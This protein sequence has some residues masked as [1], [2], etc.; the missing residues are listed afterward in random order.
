MALQYFAA[1]RRWEGGEGGGGHVSTVLKPHM[2]ADDLRARPETLT[3][4]AARL[5]MI[6]SIFDWVTVMC[7]PRS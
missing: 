1:P 2:R 5:P 6:C 3:R 7:S 4:A